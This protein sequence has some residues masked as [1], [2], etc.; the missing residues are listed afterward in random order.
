MEARS[1]N[2]P[3]ILRIH[4]G[5]TLSLTKASISTE[6]LRLRSYLNGTAIDKMV[7]ASEIEETLFEDKTKLS[8]LSLVMGPD[9]VRVTGLLSPTEK[10]EPTMY[11]ARS[12]SGGL[13]HVVRSIQRPFRSKRVMLESRKDN[14]P[15]KCTDKTMPANVTVE[16]YVVSDYQHN[17]RFEENGLLDLHLHLH[18]QRI[19]YEGAICTDD[20]VA[21]A[22]DVPGSYS[23]VLE[24][25]HELGHSMGASHDGS[26]PNINLGNHP[27]SLDCPSE[28][29]HIMT[30][31]DGGALRYKFS[32]CNKKEIRYVLRLRGKSCWDIKAKQ[33]YTVKGVYPGALLTP[34][35]FCRMRYKNNN[36]YSLTDAQ[37]P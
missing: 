27:G 36:M 13:P 33:S 14:G 17:R 24:A 19:A 23:G 4:R 29:G 2:A 12:V 30:Y 32:E 21:M 22:E 25:A 16:V 5:L 37:F 31:V 26:E 9:G 18:Q 10:I 1:G 15:L 28:S 3:L 11:G 20:S 6:M 8:T 7:K 35:Q 34:Q